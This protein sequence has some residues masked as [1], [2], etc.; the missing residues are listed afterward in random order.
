M[1]KSPIDTMLDKVEWKELPLPETETVT[2]DDLPYATHTGILRIGNYELECI[3]LNT[4]ERLFT[5][6]S[7]ARFFGAE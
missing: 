6:E 4:G 2:D 1:S 5:A 3:V 7:I